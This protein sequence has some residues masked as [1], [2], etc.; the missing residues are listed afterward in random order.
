MHPKHTDRVANSVDLD[1]TSSLIWVYTICLY[2][3][4]WKFLIIVVTF[5]SCNFRTSDSSQVRG[6]ISWVTEHLPF[7][8]GLL[9]GDSSPQQPHRHTQYGWQCSEWGYEW[10]LFKVLPAS[11]GCQYCWYDW[12][13]GNQEAVCRFGLTGQSEVCR[14][15]SFFCLPDKKTCK[16]SLK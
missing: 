9:L 10:R 14:V 16:L 12:I 6:P 5:L 3:S 4:V 1:Q 2:L 11:C 8:S 13:E 15:R 7:P